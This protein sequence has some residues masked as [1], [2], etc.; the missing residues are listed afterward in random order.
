[1]IVQNNFEQIDWLGRMRL[2]A[3]FHYL[4]D[5]FSF[6]EVLIKSDLPL[7][8]RSPSAKDINENSDFLTSP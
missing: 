4:E 7:K 3:W 8:T 5:S 6:R 1:M 2:P